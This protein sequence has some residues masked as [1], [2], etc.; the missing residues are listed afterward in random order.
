MNDHWRFLEGWTNNLGLYDEA[1]ATAQDGDILVELGVYRGRGLCYLA[2]RA[3]ESGKHLHIHGVDIFSEKEEQFVREQLGLA[4]V[5]PDTIR[6]WREPSWEAAQR[7]ADGSVHWVYIDADHGYE[8]CKRDILAW[9][10]KV[11]PGGTLCGDDYFDQHPGVIQAV[12]EVLGPLAT[13]VG[14]G[15][16]AVGAWQAVAPPPAA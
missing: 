2:A 16:R 3:Q 13:P 6:I 11:K 14:L 7:F 4:G 12:D 8:A 5:D 1:V 10:P 9:R 15:W